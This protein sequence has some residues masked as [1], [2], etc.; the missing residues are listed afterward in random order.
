MRTLAVGCLS[1]LVHWMMALPCDAAVTPVWHYVR[2]IYDGN[3]VE[4]E[5][6][7]TWIFEHNLYL[8]EWDTVWIVPFLQNDVIA[9][10]FKDFYKP[11]TLR[12][13]EGSTDLKITEIASTGPITLSDGSQWIPNPAYTPY[14]S[15]W[16]VGDPITLAGREGEYYLLNG[17]AS[18]N[19]TSTYA[20]VTRK[21]VLSSK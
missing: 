17:G 12:L 20:L 14:T 15:T 5:D 10:M 2:E 16:V 21:S 19:T 11:T 4:L 3:T 9:I 1:L 18:W 8:N 7:S 13:V 6:G